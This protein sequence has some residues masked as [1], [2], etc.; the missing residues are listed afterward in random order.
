[1][2][3]GGFTLCRWRCNGL[4]R[5]E[6]PSFQVPGA[7]VGDQLAGCSPLPHFHPSRGSFIS[8][9]IP[10]CPV[11]SVFQPSLYVCV[12]VCVCVCVFVHARVLSHV[13]LCDPVDCSPPGSLVYRIFQARIPEWVADSFS[14]GST[15]PRDRT[16]VSYVSCIGR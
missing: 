11:L 16:C 8:P 7:G 5:V 4:Q 3:G 13:Q 14:R 10:S 2:K 6:G 12:C 1:M 15:Q 9:S